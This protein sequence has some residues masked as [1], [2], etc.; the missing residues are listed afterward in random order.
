MKCAQFLLRVTHHCLVD[1][2]GGQ[3]AAVQVR[4]RNA[5]SRILKDGSPPLLA[6]L[7]F[8]PGLRLFGEIYCGPNK[9]HEVAL[10][11]YDGTSDRMLVFDGSVGEKKAVVRLV[12]SILHDASLKEIPNPLPILRMNPVKPKVSARTIVTRFDVK[13][14]EHFRRSRYNP[15]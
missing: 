15:G 13:W 2:V 9:F 10:L 5:D 14:P 3:K 7:Q 12:I 11:V 4:Q 1:M 6:F 8:N